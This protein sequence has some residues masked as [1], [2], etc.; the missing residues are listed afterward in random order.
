[1]NILVSACLLGDSVRYD[2]QSKETPGIKELADSHELFRFC[3][4]VSGGLAVPRL[5]A[6]LTGSSLLILNGAGGGVYNTKGEDVTPQFLEGARNTLE[7]C[8]E[9]KIQAAIL[10]EKSPSCGVRHIYDGSFSGNLVK[11]AGITAQLLQ[12]N[13]I[14]V[15]TEENY[16]DLLEQ[17]EFYT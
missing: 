2:G 16:R 1:M 13:G 5:P 14:R 15:Y 10:K 7:Y 12:L 3:P 11:G 17:A 9:H 8:R 4:E 6:E